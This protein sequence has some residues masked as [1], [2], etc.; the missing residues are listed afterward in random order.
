VNSAPNF[1]PA[2]RLGVALIGLIRAIAARAG[3]LMP[4]WVVAMME[5]NVRGFVEA[6]SLLAAE[7]NTK[8]F[9]EAQP[10]PRCKSAPR[11]HR[12]PVQTSPI[13]GSRTRSAPRPGKISPPLV[14]Q[15]NLP[16]EE[17]AGASV[18]AAEVREWPAPVTRL[19]LTP[20]SSP[21]PRDGPKVPAWTASTL[22]RL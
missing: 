17:T 16:R 7:I 15:P 18:V 12:S 2:E 11:K 4:R 8:G 9:N 6:L 14:E 10:A 13:E 19:S 22:A 3:W 20:V 21:P 5:D 1:P